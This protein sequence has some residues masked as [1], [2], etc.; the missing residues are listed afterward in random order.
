MREI[1]SVDEFLQSAFTFNLTLSNLGRCT[2]EHER[3][4]YEESINSPKAKE[5]ASLLSHLVDGRKGGVHLSEKAWQQYRKRISPRARASPAYKNHEGRKPN[6]SS[7]VDFLCFD[8]I[9]KEYHN[10]LTQLEKEISTSHSVSVHDKDLHQP[11]IEAQAHA[12]ADQ[13]QGGTLSAVLD[14]VKRAFERLR[15]QW[16]ESFGK[17]GANASSSF[18]PAALEAA[19]RARTL[20]PPEGD[21]P[22]IQVWQHRPE[23][24]VQLLASYAYK[25]SPTATFTMHA[26]GDALCQI[27]ASTIPSRPVAND[28]LACYRVNPKVISRLTA[29]D[30]MTDEIS[31]AENEE[32]EGQE[33]IEAMVL[34][35]SQG[36]AGEYFDPD[37]RR[38]VE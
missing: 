5:L 32:Y 28:I 24:W 30:G 12:K 36:A 29:S 7:I 8:V 2:V 6:P 23:A 3:I 38:S 34:Y 22:L 11:W 19:E 1:Q 15:R 20:P 18:P 37:D 16:G 21:H 27:K 35:G 13:C 33:A 25:R 14:E 4:A 26:F 9:G 31:E 10:V 17:D